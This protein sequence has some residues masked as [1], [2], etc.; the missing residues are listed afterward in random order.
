MKKSCC[1]LKEEKHQL[2]ISLFGEIKI[3]RQSFISEHDPEAART[4]DLQKKHRTIKD[5]ENGMAHANFTKSS[6]RRKDTSILSTEQSASEV[7]YYKSEENRD[8]MKTVQY[9]W[10]ILFRLRHKR[11]STSRN[12]APVDGYIC[13]K[14]SLSMLSL[15]RL[16]N[17]LGHSQ[18]AF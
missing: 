18:F 17:E 1:D 11:K 9:F 15:V 8:E 10:D 4:E 3:Q 6:S 5:V 2:L 16:C 7:T 13:S 12:L 14:D